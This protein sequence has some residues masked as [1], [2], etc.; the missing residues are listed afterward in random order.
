MPQPELSNFLKLLPSVQIESRNS[1]YNCNIFGVYILLLH[2]LVLDQ[3]I[4]WTVVLLFDLCW[5]LFYWGLFFDGHFNFHLVLGSSWLYFWY[6]VFTGTPQYLFLLLYK[7]IQIPQLW[8]NIFRFL[9]EWCSSRQSTN[10]V[11]LDIALRLGQY[12]TQRLHTADTNPVLNCSSLLIDL[13]HFLQNS[14]ELWVEKLWLTLDQLHIP[15]WE[16]NHPYPLNQIALKLI[17]KDLCQDEQYLH[18]LL[19]WIACYQQLLIIL[20]IE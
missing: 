20:N 9:L 19:T 1:R 13:V 6:A 3:K 4:I 8:S 7:Q 2:Y 10:K 15:W 18:H 11:H 12:P 16:M 5:L 17:Q 14:L